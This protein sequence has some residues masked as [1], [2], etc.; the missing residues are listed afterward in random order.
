MQPLRQIIFRNARS[1]TGRALFVRPPVAGRSD[2]EVTRV[3]RSPMR[4]I[5]LV[6]QGDSR[7]TTQP[8][9]LRLWNFS[10]GKAFATDLRQ[11]F[12]S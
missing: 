5:G 9:A 2:P 3:A 4:L 1:R 6:R 8:R 10:E 12:A 11:A 7:L